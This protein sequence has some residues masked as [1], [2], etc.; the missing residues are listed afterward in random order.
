MARWRAMQLLDVK[1]A[2]ICGNF[3]NGKRIYMEGPQGFEQ[4]FPKNAVLLLLKKIHGLKQ[5]ALAFWREL[6]KAFRSMKYGRSK[7]DP[8]LYFR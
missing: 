2:F 8:W 3:E 6:L 1:G 7:A 4:F 5:A